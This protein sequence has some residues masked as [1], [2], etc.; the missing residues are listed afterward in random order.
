MDHRSLPFQRK[1]LEDFK[2]HLKVRKAHNRAL[3]Y[4]PGVSAAELL[5]QQKINGETSSE[6]QNIEANIKAIEK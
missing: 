3:G 2:E 4:H 6:E 1:L 5:E